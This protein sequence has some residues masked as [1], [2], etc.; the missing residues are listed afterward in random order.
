MLRARPA[1]SGMRPRMLGMGGWRQGWGEN[2]WVE[3]L[4]PV[5]PVLQDT[6]WEARTEA[7]AGEDAGADLF[8]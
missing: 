2:W 5:R 7:G 8:C 6:D 1:L 4:L 3:Q